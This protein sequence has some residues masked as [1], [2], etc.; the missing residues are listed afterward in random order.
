M[1]EPRRFN[2][3]QRTALYLAQDGCCAEC[4]A[5]LDR[6]WHADHV[7]PH[8]RHGV[9]D[10]V[11]GQA[12]CPPCNLKKGSSMGADV[13][14]WQ[15]EA[16]VKF[17]SERPRD[18]L[19]AA[20]PGSGKTRF[21]LDLARRLLDD[22][23]IEQVVVVVPSDSLRTQWADAAQPRGLDLMPASDPAD[24]RK[25]DGYVVTYQQIA[26]G[27][28]PTVRSSMRHK[29]LAVLDELHHAGDNQ[30]WGESLQHA[31][32]LAT[33]RLGL[34]G[35]PWRRDPSSPIPFVRY[36][37]D[38][39]ADP[40]Y[41][42]GYGQA[43]VDGVCRRIYFDAYDGEAKWVDC[44][45]VV[46]RQLGDGLSDDDVPAALRTALDPGQQWMPSLLHKAHE[47][48]MELR[49]EVADAG[50][51][52]VAG[53]QSHAVAYAQMLYT[54]T[55]E[56]P[57]LV[58]DKVPDA[59]ALIDRYRTGTSPWLVAIKM[60]SEGVDIPRLAVGVYATATRT[61][62]FFRQVV[63]RLVRVRSV[64]DDLPARLFIP[65]VP[66]LLNHA[67]EIEEELLHQL[68]LDTEADE[69]AR[70]EAQAGQRTFELIDPLSTSEANFSSTIVSG[71]QLTPEQIAA[72]EA[73]CH[74][75]GMP[76][77]AAPGLARMLRAAGQ[78]VAEVVYVPKP[79]AEPMHRREKLL[80]YE[81]EKLARKVAHRL[82]IS[83]R[84][85]NTDLLKAGLPRRKQMSIEQLETARDLLAARLEW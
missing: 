61:P 24:T 36:R 5:V 47:G 31:V 82:E 84:E 59:K 67:R 79:D 65:A 78:S 75:F 17:R 76:L 12:L 69:K 14:V 55:G 45:V 20:T 50:G 16:D 29:T 48:L 68:A 53:K 10:V 56:Q 72:A 49:G 43:V 15:R 46:A 37:A 28:A 9:T 64:T 22:G 11:N 19:V 40:D 85:V 60:V 8:S 35:T 18:F 41:A 71:D 57:V 51:L 1:T 30:T 21:A 34:T 54:L 13:R 66:A 7:Q 80:R 83:A 52:V 2:R 70:A 77:A 74:E 33:H 3:S 44:G 39:L 25:G 6:G 27:W 63:G 62:L 73:R 81:V 38:G 26:Q 42:Y 4:G 23:T 32:E 58:H